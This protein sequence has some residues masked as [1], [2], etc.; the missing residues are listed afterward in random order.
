MLREISPEAFRPYPSIP[1]WPIDS[2]LTHRFRPV[3]RS[4]GLYKTN[5]SKVIPDGKPTI[6]TATR[7]ELQLSASV[8]LD[9]YLLRCDTTD[10][11]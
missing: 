5:T 6:S 10:R 8:R 7:A 2:G 9:V 4:P 3:T 1:A 11:R